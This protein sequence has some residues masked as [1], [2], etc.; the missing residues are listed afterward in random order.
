MPIRRPDTPLAA[1][2]FDT[3]KKP[4]QTPIELRKQRL[5]SILA[6][7]RAEN[8][9]KKVKSDS[10]QKVRVEQFAQKAKDRGMT[11][12]QYSKKLEKDKK[13]PDVTSSTPDYKQRSGINP[14]PGSKCSK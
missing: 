3:I 12:E 2:V 8:A 1:T 6:A 9:A 7:K 5:D 10:L 14:C 13:K 11:V 4:Q